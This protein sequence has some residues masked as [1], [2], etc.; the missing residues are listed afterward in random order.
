MAVAEEL[1]GAQRLEAWEIAPRRNFAQKII[2][3]LVSF[4]K[5]K[6]LG[7]F[8]ATL[9]LIL[10]ISAIFGPGVELG[11]GHV[12]LVVGVVA[13]VTGFLMIVIA[14]FMESILRGLAVFLA[15]LFGA[16]V[17]GGLNARALRTPLILMVGGLGLTAVGYGLF[18]ADVAV[19]SIPGIV[20]YHYQEYTLGKNI[21]E[22]PSTSHWMGTDQLGR[23]L[24]SRLVYGARLS[25]MIGGS[26]FL[27]STFM[28]TTLTI[29]SAY[30]IRTV[31]LILTRVIEIIDFLPDLILIIALFSIYGATPSTLILTL[32]VL[33][34][35]QT[36]RVLRSVVIGLRSMPYI[37][38]AKSLGAT[39]GRII[40]RHILPNLAYLIIVGATG[41]LST[42]I[43]IESGL[44]ILGFGINPNYPSLGNLLNGSRQYLRV[45]PHLA[46]FPGIVIFMLL[47]GSRL[48]GDA[49]RDVL[50]PRLRGGR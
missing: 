4:S 3:G 44:A 10:V 32:G 25:F 27:I 46:I 18:A 17:Y 45:A 11:P 36:G 6:P 12:L 47:L 14:A 5:R 9:L 41:A 2:V 8:G 21:L 42:A 7:A 22:G 23:D 30:Y 16:L 15:L 39:D 49:L 33:G 13:A 50:D 29:L 48:L 26:V 24:F 38:A 1:V 43:L 37:E 35:F 20:R 28:S 34:G 31:D 19:V 40:L